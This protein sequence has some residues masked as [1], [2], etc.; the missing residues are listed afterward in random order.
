MSTWFQWALNIDN[1]KEIGTSSSTRYT[2]VNGTP[3][4]IGTDAD[5]HTGRIVPVTNIGAHACSGLAKM[6][7]TYGQ[8]TGYKAEIALWPMR[9]Y[10]DNVAVSPPAATADNRVYLLNAA[11]FSDTDTNSAGHF[12]GQCLGVFATGEFNGFYDLNLL[13]PS[14]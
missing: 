2:L 10:T 5:S 4:Y 13:G 11:T 7:T 12:Y 3:I 8:Y 1:T 14:A 6:A 9:I